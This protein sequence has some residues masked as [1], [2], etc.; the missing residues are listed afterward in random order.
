MVYNSGAFQRVTNEVDMNKIQS[1]KKVKGTVEPEDLSPCYTFI[2]IQP[3]SEKAKPNVEFLKWVNN[4]NNNE[5][6]AESG[7][8]P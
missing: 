8:C 7:V 6:K 5:W 2:R 1:T 4:G 3:Y